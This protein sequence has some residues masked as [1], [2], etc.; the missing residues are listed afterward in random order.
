MRITRFLQES[1]HTNPFQK[2]PDSRFASIHNF[3]IIF[4]Q[5]CWARAIFRRIIKSDITD[6]RM[7][8][9]SDELIWGGLGNLRFLQVNR[10]RRTCGIRDPK[11]QFFRKRVLGVAGKL[12][13]SK[14]RNFFVRLFS[15]FSNWFFA[16]LFYTQMW[17]TFLTLSHTSQSV[18]NFPKVWQK[19][20]KVW[21]SVP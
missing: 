19:C 9:Q 6:R 20:E 3:W 17:C 1:S 5:I 8:R 21:G 12:N 13:F 4:H 16:W 10:Y 18:W 15:N 11:K 7:D 2:I 14:K